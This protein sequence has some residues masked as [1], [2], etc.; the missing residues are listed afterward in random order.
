M[1]D[2]SKTPLLRKSIILAETF[3]E[4]CYSQKSYLP[5][6]SSLCPFTGIKP[7]LWSEDALL[8]KHFLHEALVVLIPCWLFLGR[9]E[10]TLLSMRCASQNNWVD[11]ALDDKSVSS[12]C[13]DHCLVRVSETKSGPR[14]KCAVIDYQCLQWAQRGWE[15]M[16]AMYMLIMSR[17][18]SPG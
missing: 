14:E 6:P 7:A 9:P 13:L 5:R 2:S 8:H 18:A 3:S 11:E 15:D 16:Y 1:G 17:E 10:P 12:G 4:L